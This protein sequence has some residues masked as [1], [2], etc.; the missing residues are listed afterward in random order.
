MMLPIRVNSFAK[1]CIA[2]AGLAGMLAGCSAIESVP[3]AHGTDEYVFA[4]SK[5]AEQPE[6]ELRAQAVCPEG[7]E[8]LSSEQDFNRKE[9]RVRCVENGR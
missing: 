6:C 7:Y 1:Q 5:T 8:T 2:L 9:L 4:C 3:P